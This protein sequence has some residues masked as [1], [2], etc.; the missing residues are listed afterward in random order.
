[1]MPEVGKVVTSTRARTRESR[2]A[3]QTQRSYACACVLARTRG[4][5]AGGGRGWI[6]AASASLWLKR[7]A[8]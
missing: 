4:W 8:V 5:W 3:R 7:G 2:N 6:E 1:L